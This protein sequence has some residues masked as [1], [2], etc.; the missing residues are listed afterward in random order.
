MIDQLFNVLSFDSIPFHDAL[1]D[2]I[3]QHVFE[4]R[5]YTRL[6][7]GFIR[8]GY[9]FRLHTIADQRCLSMMDGNKK[10]KSSMSEATMGNF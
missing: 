8:I 4:V 1:N 10:D 6:V 3:V 9:L 2:G 5:L 7:P